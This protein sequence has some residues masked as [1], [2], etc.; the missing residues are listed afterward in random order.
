MF[1]AK[2][3]KNEYPFSDGICSFWDSHSEAFNAL[4]LNNPKKFDFLGVI[5]LSHTPSS[6][7]KSSDEVIGIWYLDYSGSSCKFHKRIC[8]FKQDFIVNIKKQDK[9]FVTYSANYEEG[10]YVK[11]INDFFRLYGDDGKFFHNG[12]E[13]QHHY[14]NVLDLPDEPTLR[15]SAKQILIK[16]RISII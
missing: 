16:R 6:H 1:R 14:F 4:K 13:W 10:K 5:F 11:P 9:E 2:Y 12:K 15:K 7:P 8:W 3:P